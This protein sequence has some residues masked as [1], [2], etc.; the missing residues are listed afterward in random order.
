MSITLKAARVNAGLTQ[1]EAAKALGIAVD[2]IRQYEAG[3][4][5]PD[6]PMIGKIEEV[7][8]VSYNDSNFFS[9]EKTD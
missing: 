2:T 9:N 4:T 1:A 7:Y 5:F 3:K 6:V 8:G